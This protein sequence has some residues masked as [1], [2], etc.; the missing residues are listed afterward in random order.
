MLQFA[1]LNHALGNAI[2]GKPALML[3][4]GAGRAYERTAVAY[5]RVV[6]NDGQM[7]VGS[8]CL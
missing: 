3:T 5:F 1:G 7:L 8:R 4:G 2:N 6:A